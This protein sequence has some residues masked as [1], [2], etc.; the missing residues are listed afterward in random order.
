VRRIVL[1]PAMFSSNSTLDHSLAVFLASFAGGEDDF[2]GEEIAEVVL[3]W[4]GSMLGRR[5]HSI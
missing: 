1:S 3:W 2:S 4:R 5:S